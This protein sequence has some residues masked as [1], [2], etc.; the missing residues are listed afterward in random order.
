M[1]GESFGIGIFLFVHLVS[2]VSVGLCATLSYRRHRSAGRAVLAGIGGLFI[3]PLV[4]M[5][6]IGLARPRPD[7][8]YRPRG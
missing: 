2:M 4:V 6:G 1:N 8:Q 5:V 3:V 7:P